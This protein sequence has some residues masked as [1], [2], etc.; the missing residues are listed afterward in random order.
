MLS[1]VSL[2][3]SS[4][5]THQ[6]LWYLTAIQHRVI[7]QKTTPRKPK[8]TCFTGLWFSCDHRII[9]SPTSVYHRGL[10]GPQTSLLRFRIHRRY[11]RKQ[12]AEVMVEVSTEINSQPAH[13]S[14]IHNHPKMTLKISSSC[15]YFLMSYG[16]NN[17]TNK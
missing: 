6:K 2:L 11:L 16:C 1:F 10:C 9:Q 8:M 5:V 3:L 14:N 17:Q 7:S 13:Q 15:I 4:V 12:Y